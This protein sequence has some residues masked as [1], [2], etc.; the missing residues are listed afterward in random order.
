MNTSFRDEAKRLC[1]ERTLVLGFGQVSDSFRAGPKYFFR[2]RGVDCDLVRLASRPKHAFM[3]SPHQRGLRRESVSELLQPALAGDLQR[4]AGRLD[5]LVNHARVT[6]VADCEFET[7]TTRRCEALCA[8]LSHCVSSHRSQRIRPD[9]LRELL[10]GAD[11]ELGA[12]E[13]HILP[14]HNTARR[15]PTGPL[16]PVEHAFRDVL[17]MIDRYL[18]GLDPAEPAHAIA[19]AIERVERL[20]SCYPRDDEF[21]HGLAHAISGLEQAKA[22]AEFQ[23]A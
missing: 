5:F 10:D 2:H 9:T 14:R 22:A 3:P 18:D 7:L 6:L 1:Q 12:W 16:A 19:R 11:A 13:R 15:R 17:A 23:T 21:Q 20:M 4:C 8:V